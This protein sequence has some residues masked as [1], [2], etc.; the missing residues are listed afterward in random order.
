[1]DKREAYRI[2]H[3]YPDREILFTHKVGSVIYEGVF[4]RLDKKEQKT[5]YPYTVET[6]GTARRADTGEL[7]CINIGR[8]YKSM[9]DAVVHIFNGRN[10]MRQIKNKYSCLEDILFN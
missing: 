6:S 7:T 9:E 1:M 10:E 5:Y 8:R 2:C 3:V 4:R